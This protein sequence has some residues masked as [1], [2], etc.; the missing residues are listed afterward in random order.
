MEPNQ[1]QIQQNQEP[2]LNQTNQVIGQ[3]VNTQ[4]PK[5]K[6]WIV[7]LV[8]IIVL[9]G[10]GWFYYK[11]VSVD[12][13]SKNINIQ[14]VDENVKTEKKIDSEFL[15]YTNALRDYISLLKSNDTA[16]YRAKIN[17]AVSQKG[18]TEERRINT[19]A[20]YD[21]KTEDEKKE[22]M[23]NELANFPKNSG[24]I[25]DHFFS[26]GETVTK[27][28]KIAKSGQEY[29]EITVVWSEGD[30]KITQNIVFGMD[31]A[32]NKPFVIGIK[33][34][35]V[36]A[37]VSEDDKKA[38]IASLDKIQKIVDSGNVNNF[39]QYAKE[40]QNVGDREL[41]QDLPDE[42]WKE[43]IDLY[44]VQ[45]KEIKESLKSPE[46]IKWASDGKEVTMEINFDF[47]DSKDNLNINKLIDFVKVNNEWYMKLSMD[48]E[49]TPKNTKQ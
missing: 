22:E 38:I 35:V 46:N 29:D 7:V 6:I 14:N 31:Y 8:V 15:I 11:N 23:R 41:K 43:F 42:S 34:A 10:V 39:K 49:M 16:N 45:L 27:E 47:S 37:P 33:T 12:T 24:M 28:H 20:K 26:V 40:S 36:S 44:K 19:L 48:V 2:V 9:V 5:S 25:E 32:T 13:N 30:S 18:F 1:N 17:M 3:D 21:A 4:Q